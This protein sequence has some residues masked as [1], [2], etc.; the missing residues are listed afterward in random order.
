MTI[1]YPLIDEMFEICKNA[2]G[3]SVVKKIIA[4]SQNTHRSYISA[5][6]CQNLIKMS[7]S[8]FGQYIIEQI[9]DS[10]D[11]QSAAEIF[12]QVSLKFR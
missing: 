3:L 7:Q 4:V 2:N 11:I 9:L 10:W 6:I 8:K 1:F 5:Q 12:E